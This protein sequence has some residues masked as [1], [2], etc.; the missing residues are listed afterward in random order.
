LQAHSFAQNIGRIA[1][2]MANPLPCDTV[3]SILNT[4]AEK[5]LS[6]ATSVYLTLWWK[7]EQHLNID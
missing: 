6:S 3:V 2:I 7:T 5:Q 4:N 1:V